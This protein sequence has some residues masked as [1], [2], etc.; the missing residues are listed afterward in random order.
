MDNITIEIDGKTIKASPGT[1]ILQNAREQG[2]FIPTLCYEEKLAPYGGC[3]LCM[4]EIT[5]NKRQR[6]V[7]SCI[8]TVE[9]GLIV[10]TDTE[11]VNRI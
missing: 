10:K 2:I 1:T 9:E 7:A 3:R 11:Q 8:Y 6:L 5:N 4:V